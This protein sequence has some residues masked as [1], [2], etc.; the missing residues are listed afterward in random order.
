[1]KNNKVLEKKGKWQKPNFWKV[2]AVLCIVSFLLVVVHSVMRFHEGSSFMKASE[3]QMA[4]ARQLVED[5]LRAHNEVPSTF[6]ITVSS[7]IR[8]QRETEPPVHH[9]Q[10]TA[11]KNTTQHTYLV[12]IDTQ[13]IEL[14]TTTV[15]SGQL[16]KKW[17]AQGRAHERPFH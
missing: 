10:V 15:I 13:D 3:Q 11:Q 7:R 4:L 9:I 6:V 16:A 1:M 17:E 14:H 2:V 5:D 8:Q 12:N